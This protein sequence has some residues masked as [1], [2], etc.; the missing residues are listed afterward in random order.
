MTGQLKIL[1]T[2]VFTRLLLNRHLGIIRWF[3]LVILFSGVSLVKIEK[4]TSKKVD[5]DIDP[6]IGF[7]AVLIACKFNLIKIL[8]QNM[9]L[10]GICSGFA[11]V[12]FEKIVK[13]TGISLWIYNVQLAGFS[14][15]TN[16]LVMFIIDREKI[17]NHGIFYGYEKYVVIATIIDSI[18]GLIV[19]LVIKYSDN[20][21]K[22]FAS[23]SSV[24]LS[25]IVAMIFFNFQLTNLF[26]IGSSLVV[27]S[28]II[29]SNPELILSIPIFK[30]CVKDRS[31]FV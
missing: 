8:F 3:G 21:L 10:I 14:I 2:A 27:V 7:I 13:N 23:S 31:V 18:G 17:M 29:Y 24:V 19:A 30:F 22:G 4:L 16:A 5:N 20:I 1:T 9:F 6:V 11:G 15:I 28:I 12:Y 26:A 25:C